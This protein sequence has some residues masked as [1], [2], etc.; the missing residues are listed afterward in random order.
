MIFCFLE[1]FFLP[2]F[3]KLIIFINKFWFFHSD[4]FFNAYSIGREQKFFQN[5]GKLQTKSY[6]SR[7]MYES[8][9]C[10]I[11]FQRST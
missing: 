8:F 6:I 1:F 7:K 3:K 9:Y 2:I 4:L 10:S 11:F 5:A